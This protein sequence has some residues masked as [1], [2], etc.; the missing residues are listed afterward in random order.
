[1]SSSPAS[2]QQFEDVH[3][4]LEAYKER[5]KRDDEKLVRELE[6]Q[7]K[8]MGL[9]K[10]VFEARLGQLQLGVDFEYEIR[11]NIIEIFPAGGC[12]TCDF[13]PIHYRV[14]LQEALREAGFDY[15]VIV[16]TAGPYE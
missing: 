8:M 15:D 5:L 12:A 16:R 10:E 1:M 13:V 9:S 3:E 4:F 6:R 2:A 7:Y 11:G 14:Q